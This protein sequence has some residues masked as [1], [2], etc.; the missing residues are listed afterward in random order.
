LE[1]TGLGTVLDV[2]LFGQRIPVTVERDPL[3]DPKGERIKA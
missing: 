3:W 1:H 2:E